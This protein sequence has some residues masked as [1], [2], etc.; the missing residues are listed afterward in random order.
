[1]ETNKVLSAL[2]YFSIFFAGFIF[3]II[4]Y[5]VA[6]NPHVKKDAKAALLSHII[7]I[8]AIPFLFAGIFLDIGIF[9]TG[10]GLPIFLLVTVGL[11]ILI[12]IIIVIWNVYKGI[13]V[14]L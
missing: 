6:E 5:F 3:P 9:A 2:C 8:I 4:V 10:S 12:N 1:M 13:K 11:F 7:P 14:L